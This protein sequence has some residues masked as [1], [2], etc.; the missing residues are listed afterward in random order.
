MGSVK[1]WG[2]LALLLTFLAL[3]TWFAGWLGRRHYKRVLELSPRQRRSRLW[4]RLGT[5]TLFT[6]LLGWLVLMLSIGSDPSLL[7]EGTAASWMYGLYALGL[8]AL[9]GVLLIVIHTVLCWM[10]PRRSRWVLLGETLLAF[11]AVYLAW[12]IVAFRMISFNTRF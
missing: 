9:A 6:T 1:L 3:L 10:A 4:G 7:L 5:L 12:L 11:S 8:L 2:T